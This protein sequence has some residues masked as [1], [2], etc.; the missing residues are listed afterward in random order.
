MFMTVSTIE[1]TTPYLIHN[2]SVSVKQLIQENNTLATGIGSDIF[3]RFGY[4]FSMEDN[5]VTDRIRKK[6]GPLPGPPMRQYTVRIEEDLG[7]WG[8]RQ[9]PGGLSALI[10]RLLK[11]EQK[12]R[13]ELAAP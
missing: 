3:A 2:N 13:T 10:R 1:L 8:K 6:P 5:P 9:R 12:R 7:E 11:E 4:D